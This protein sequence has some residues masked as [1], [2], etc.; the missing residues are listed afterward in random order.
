MQ[1]LPLNR[2]GKGGSKTLHH[3]RPPLTESSKRCEKHSGDSRHYMFMSPYN[4]DS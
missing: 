4:Y 2:F 1:S 3:A